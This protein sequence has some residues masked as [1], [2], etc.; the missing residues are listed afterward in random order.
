MTQLPVPLVLLAALLLIPSASASSTE[1][2]SP[3][4]LAA[5]ADRVVRAR[6]IRQQQEEGH[7]ALG[8]L[9]TVSTL[10]VQEVLMGPPVKE[11]EVEQLGGRRGAARS[12][13]PGDA[14]ISPGDDAVWF[15]RCRDPE[16]PTRCTLVG[17]ASGQLRWN[18]RTG[19]AE[20]HR[21]G[22]ATKAYRMEALR[23]LITEGR[24]AR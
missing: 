2:L 9:R 17:H 1:H 13:V 22:A 16:A 3:D 20:A 12:G 15:L 24:E 7:D 6:V 23:A 5:H 21:R 10:E 11:L 4:R 18:P 8:G 19:Q 14:Q